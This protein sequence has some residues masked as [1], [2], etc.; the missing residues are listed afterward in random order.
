M[1]TSLEAI[2]KKA[3]QCRKHQFRNLYRELNEDYLKRCWQRL[4]KRAAPGVDKV[5]YQ[6]YEAN[7]DEN[8]RELVEKLKAKRYRARLI[9]RCYIPKDN[10]KQ[11]P[12]GIPAIE[13]KLLQYAVSQLLQAIWESD[14]LPSSYGYRPGKGAREAVDDLQNELY[15][16]WYRYVVDADIKGFFDNIDHDWLIRMLQERIDD[17][18]FISLIRKWLKAGVLD[19]DGKVLHP[20]TGTPQGGSVS[21]VL[22]N[23]YMH[24]VLNQWFNK[25]IVKQSRGK[26]HLC[27]YADDFVAAFEHK[28]D[29]ERFY[30]SLGERLKKFGLSLSEEKTRIVKFN[31]FEKETSSSFDFLGF[32]FRWT[33]SKA[34]KNWLKRSTSKKKHLKS[35]RTIKEWIKHNRD[36]PLKNFF[37]ILNSKLRGYY[38]YYGIEGNLDILRAFHFNVI[39]LLFRW[40]NRRSQRKSYGW[41]GF[42][43][44]LTHFRIIEPRIRPAATAS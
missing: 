27:V 32:E 37:R 33:T 22:A 6:Q 16:S 14:F 25:V 42:C 12:L 8:I 11:R 18:A 23:I 41:S 17:R 40:L 35:L 29:A 20:A 5:S 15:G 19:T 1:Q 9:R 21:P 43:E 4:N 2:A 34:G 10:G 31:R 38:N 24:Y 30:R 3:E 28:D 13:D 7:L 44:M 26:A 39:A 36:L